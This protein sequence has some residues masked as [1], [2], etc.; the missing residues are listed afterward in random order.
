MYLSMPKNWRV[1]FKIKSKIIKWKKWFN[2]VGISQMIQCSLVYAFN[3]NLKLSQSAWS[4]SQEKFKRLPRRKILTLNIFHKF[5]ILT[6]SRQKSSD[7][8]AGI[9]VKMVGKIRSWSRARF[10]WKRLSSSF[11]YLFRL[12]EKNRSHSR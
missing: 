2:K 11:G 1:I 8:A 5:E 9:Q 12:E 4:I 10:N 6:K 3:G 7:R